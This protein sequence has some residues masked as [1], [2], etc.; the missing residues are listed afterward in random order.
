MELLEITQHAY[1]PASSPHWESRNQVYE[2]ICETLPNVEV[3]DAFAA[4]PAPRTGR[5]TRYT[6]AF[7]INDHPTSKFIPASIV[8]VPLLLLIFLRGLLT[9]LVQRLE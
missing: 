3:I 7:L 5:R 4:P 8:Q 1:S 2:Y 9:S 6:I